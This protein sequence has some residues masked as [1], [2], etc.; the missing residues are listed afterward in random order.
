MNWEYESPRKA[1]GTTLVELGKERED[2]VVMDA[3][4][5]TSTK[6]AMFGKEFPDRFFNVGLQ[7]QNMMG[8]A[9]GLARSGKT[10]FASSFAVFATGRAYDQIR[11]S[12]AYPKLNVKIVATHGG[13]TV[14]EDGASHQMIEDIGLM[15]GLPNMRVIVPVDSNEVRSVIRFVASKPGPFYVRLTRTALPN[16]TDGE[17]EF[18]RAR[19]MRDGE[20]A[21]I[22]ATGI[23]VSYSLLAAEIL[24]KN[25]LDV[26][27]IN[28]STIKPID[29]DTIVKAAKET[30]MIMTVEDHNIYNGLGSAVA[31][32][33]VE[34]YPVPMRRHGMMDVFGRSGKW[35]ALLEYY[36]MDDR[37]IAREMLSFLKEV[38]G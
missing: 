32:V 5:S 18:G 3:D 17:F 25:G 4:L 13:V 22:I 19:V 28:I 33:L 9:A 11:Q 34:N 15:R 35:N 12:I 2:I 37:G 16:L 27:V 23:E 30:G 14:G 36:G 1:Y 8:I 24:K 6:T 10:V 38:K 26:R 7:E 31:E 29:V 21:T 20:D